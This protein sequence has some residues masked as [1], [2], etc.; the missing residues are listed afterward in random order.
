MKNYKLMGVLLIFVLI[1][2]A[3]TI[4]SEAPV[5]PP[6]EVDKQVVDEVTTEPEV[7]ETEEEGFTFTA[8]DSLDK[9]LN[10]DKV[11]A[12]LKEMPFGATSPFMAYADDNYATII[13]HKGLLIYDLN[14]GTLKN[15]IDAETKLNR[16]QG[17][18][19]TVVLG[20]DNYILAYNE[21]FSDTVPNADFLI[22]SIDEVKLMAG[23][24]EVIEYFQS[25]NHTH[26]HDEMVR[27]IIEISD[28]QEY[29]AISTGHN[30]IVF[31]SDFNDATAWNL[32]VLDLNN[33][34]YEEMRVFD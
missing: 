11:V 23:S 21:G 27:N 29:N 34:A 33:D 15:A 24:E 28:T 8:D 10:K 14:E 6:K 2:T 9:Y 1:F 12:E 32:Y 30:L 20:K 19:A 31:R 16:T 4:Q 17:D 5:E 13:T 3:C 26:E 18:A 7:E 22:Y 25:A